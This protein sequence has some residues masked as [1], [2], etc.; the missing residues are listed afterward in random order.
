VDIS[1]LKSQFNQLFPTAT[2]QD[3][4]VVQAP[5]RVNLIGE[6]TDYNDGFVCPMAIDRTTTIVCRVRNDALVR[7]HSNLAH[8]TVEFPIDRAV[9]KAGPAWA[10]YPK[11]VAEA[12]RQKGL[13]PHGIDALVDSNVPL[14]G[15]LSSSAS[16]EIA[17]GLALLTANKA[18]LD[19][20]SLAL[21]GQWAEHHYP[22]MPCGI[23]DQFISAMGKQ[24]HA[25][26][27]DC[28]DR[29]VKH[30]PLADPTVRV[31]IA[32][33]NVKH[34]LVEGEYAAR[35]NQCKA[36]VAHLQKS[37]PQVKS[38]RDVT[39]PMLDAA[40]A[41]MDA[42]VYK[43]AKHVVTETQ[44]TL[45][46]AKSLETKNYATCGELMYGSHESLRDDY[47]VSCTELDTLVAIASSVPGVYGARMTGGGFG[48]CI[49]ALVTAD[50]V[51][52][53]TATLQ[54]DY[55][56]AH[57]KDATIFSTVPSAGAHVVK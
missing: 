20:V 31:V 42:V 30:V 17:T 45:D 40:K 51:D 39:I 19:P 5:G 46:F 22:G 27:L 4:L 54:R 44:R 38:L 16:F 57:Q 49:V 23:M 32:N 14:G 1:S 18:T 13:A 21:V 6:H 43:R 29:S 26:L 24:G 53:L 11:G 41:G 36:A 10:L 2:T 25:L 9:P 48:G 37:H 52:T 50:A 3:V 28:R 33:S 55:K 56:K 7:M 35:Q 8:E 34:A 12:L 47:Q 15:G